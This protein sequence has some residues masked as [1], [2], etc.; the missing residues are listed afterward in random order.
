MYPPPHFPMAYPQLM[1]NNG[2]VPNQVY[3]PMAQP[4]PSMMYPQ[5]FQ[6]PPNIQGPPLS[7][8]TSLNVQNTSLNTP[9]PLNPIVNNPSPSTASSDIPLS[10]PAVLRRSS[11]SI[12]LPINSSA[13]K[14]TLPSPSTK[15]R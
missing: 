5:V 2:I 3:P 4:H 6:Q 9:P 13:P 10:D 15:K 8:L 7:S 12:T 1:P 11:G 14:N